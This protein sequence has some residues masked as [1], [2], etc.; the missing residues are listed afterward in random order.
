MDLFSRKIIERTLLSTT[1]EVSCVISTIAQ[2]KKRRETELPLVIHS[3]RGGQYV[4][5]DYQQAHQLVFEYLEAFYS[6]VRI[7]SH[8]DYFSPDDFENSYDILQSMAA[9]A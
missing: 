7:H 6:T 8:C 4:L 5:T 2:A 9:S 1:M 3:D